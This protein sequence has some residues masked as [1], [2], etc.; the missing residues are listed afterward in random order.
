MKFAP[1]LTG[2]PLVNT[3]DQVAPDV[4]LIK[5]PVACGLVGEVTDA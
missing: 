5:M 2:V 4:L 1:P 3:F